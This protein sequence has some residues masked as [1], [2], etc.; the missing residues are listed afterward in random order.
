MVAVS[1]IE[2][3]AFGQKDLGR[4]EQFFV[5]FGLVPVARSE[6][7]LLLRGRSNRH[8]HYV[9][10][11]SDQPGVR[12]IAMRVE[13]ME[14][15]EEAARFPEASA[16]E[17][18]GRA[19][20]G[21]RVRL[22][23]PDGIPFE[24]VHGI[25][26]LAPLPM[27]DPLVFNHA[28]QKARTGEWQR[29]DLEP[30]AI[31]RL[32]HVA[33]TTPDYRRNAEWLQTRFGMRPSDVLI[34]GSQDNQ[35]GGFFHCRGASGWTDHHTLALFPAPVSKVHHCSFEIQDVDA[36]F[37]G[38]KYLLSKGWKP[39]WGI[40][41]HILG[42]QIFDYWFDPDG[43][44]VEHFTDGDLVRGEHQVEYHQVSDDSLAQWGPPM[45]VANFIERKP[46]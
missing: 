30:A 10:E 36:A 1:D 13:S 17:P 23:S 29:P 2:Y 41:R 19:G 21:W 39:L 26:P 43:N 24:L 5:D 22:T 34:D 46:A 11:R 42:S 9:A 7:E 32:G 31:L 6:T 25:E 35:I 12:A 33:L 37:L 15:L 38:N 27:R 14:D 18:I 8:Y 3:V 45:P 28:L 16:I 20:G 40:G 4:A 44:V